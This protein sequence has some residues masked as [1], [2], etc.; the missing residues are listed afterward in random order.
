MLK[1]PCGCQPPSFTYFV[2][3]WLL[4]NNKIAA[5]DLI[6]TEANVKKWRG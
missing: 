1:L 2:L 3:S 6:H 5:F 4:Q